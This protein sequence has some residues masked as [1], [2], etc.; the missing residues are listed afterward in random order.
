MRYLKKLIGQNNKSL[1][2]GVVLGLFIFTKVM[3]FFVFRSSEGIYSLRSVFRKIFRKYVK[4]KTV[5]NQTRCDQASS[6]NE[7]TETLLLG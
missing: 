6:T 2:I 7:M 3:Q 1:S 5:E 4:T